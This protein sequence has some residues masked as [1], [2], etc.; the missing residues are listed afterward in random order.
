MKK[1]FMMIGLL[2][3][4]GG[5]MVAS[6]HINSAREY[7]ELTKEG[8]VII[9]FYASWCMPCQELG[10]NIEKLNDDNVKV[11]KI[12][13]DDNPELQA[14]YS[15]TDAIPAL[16]FIKDGRVVKKELGSQTTAELEDE[17]AQYFY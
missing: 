17:I 5:E 6:E 11:Y 9:D 15:K 2:V 3:A 13:V 12:N 1:L 8:N 14:M 16:L 10:Y 4:F 7:N